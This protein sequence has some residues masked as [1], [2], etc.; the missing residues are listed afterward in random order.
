MRLVGLLVVAVAFALVTRVLW[1]AY[2][3]V[4][5]LGELLLASHSIVTLRFVDRGMETPLLLLSLAACLTALDRFHHAPD[6]RAALVVGLCSA[7]LVLARLDMAVVLP[8]VAIDV[9][10]RLPRRR[11]LAGLGRWVRRPGRAVPRLPPPRPPLAAHHEHD[12]QAVPGG[13]AHRR[14]RRPVLRRPPPASSPASSATTSGR[15]SARSPRRPGESGRLRRFVAVVTLALLGGVDGIRRLR[16]RRGR[17]APTGTATATIAAMVT[18]KVAFDLLVVPLWFLA[19][20]AA[21]GQVTATWAIGAAARAGSPPL[22]RLTTRRAAA[23][24]A[25]LACL[26]AFPA[27]LDWVT[28]DEPPQSAWQLEIDRA[29]DWLL[30]NR[31]PGTYGAFD[32]GLV[33]YGLERR[34]PIVEEPRRARQR[35]G[36]PGV[37][38]LTARPAPDQQHEQVDIVVNAIDRGGREGIWSCATTLYRGTVNVDDDDPPATPACTCWT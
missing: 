37:P 9:G 30:A 3:P 28:E 23:I 11:N 21:A 25:A 20:Y 31:P 14:P 18:T 17:L 16:R 26:A 6:R 32:A 4:V 12:V 19:W 38:R 2:G 29:T 10:L 27:N 34:R 8:V 24:V 1:R 7:L 5:A 35:P 36:L 13:R 15:S 22:S 33:G